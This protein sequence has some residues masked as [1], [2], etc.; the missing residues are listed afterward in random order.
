MKNVRDEIWWTVNE[1]DKYQNK[2]A[3]L[4]QANDGCFFIRF[5][6]EMWCGK[7]APLLILRDSERNTS[8]KGAWKCMAPILNGIHTLSELIHKRIKLVTSSLDF[9]TSHKSV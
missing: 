8:V 4:W 1:E 9:S 6:Y 5:R 3:N 2:N 7:N